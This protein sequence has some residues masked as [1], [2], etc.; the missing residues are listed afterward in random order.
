MSA[1]YDVIVAG[2]GTAGCVLAARLSEDPAR[3]VLLLEAG[4]DPE[5]IPEIVADAAMQTR[6]LL[7]SPYVMMYPTE[8]KVDAVCVPMQ[9]ATRDFD[10]FMTAARRVLNIDGIVITVPHK[11]AAA[12]PT[13]GSETSTSSSSGGSKNRL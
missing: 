9:V 3:Q 6:L 10:A 12:R 11:F 2:G 13:F 4:P 1:R 7:E 8:R 5:P